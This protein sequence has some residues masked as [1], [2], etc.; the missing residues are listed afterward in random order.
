[1]NRQTPS[2]IRDWIFPAALILTWAVGSTY[3]LARLGEAHRAHAVA[4]ARL[5]PQPAPATPLLARAE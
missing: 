5:S 2:R 3:T 4:A 1:M